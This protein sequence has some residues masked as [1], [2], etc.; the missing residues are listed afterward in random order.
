MI[1]AIRCVSRGVRSRGGPRRR[2]PVLYP[3]DE[4]QRR[5]IPSDAT[6]P[7]QALAAV[8][9]AVHDYLQEHLPERRP[10]LGDPRHIDLPAQLAV[11]RPSR[12]FPAPLRESPRPPKPD[13]ERGPA[14]WKSHGR[15]YFR[16][17]SSSWL[18]TSGISKCGTW[19]ALGISASSAPGIVSAMWRASSGKFAPSLSPPSTSVFT[20]IFGQS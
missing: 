3:K 9:L 12:C 6:Q 19:P 15:P 18:N 4:I 10:D 5:R 1:P 8:I 13:V 20:L 14:T 17:F 2:R 11:F 7:C 16:N